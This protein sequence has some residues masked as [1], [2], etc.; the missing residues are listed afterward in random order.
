VVPIRYVLPVAS[1]QVK[2][3]VLLA[4]LDCPGTVT[5]VEAA[6]TRDH[7]ERM[8]RYF[9][10]ELEVRD[11]DEGSEITL[12]GRPHLRGQSVSVPS[13]PS[14]AAFPIVAALLVPGSEVTLPGIIMNPTRSG[15][16]TTLREMGGDI[17]IENMR[18]AGGEP[19]ADLVVKSGVLRGVDV[20]ADR[21]P[22]MIDEYPVLAVAACFADGITRMRGL[23]ELRVKESDR[24]Q[25]VADGLKANGAT[26]RIE[27]DDLV[28]EGT[29]GTGQ[30]RAWWRHGCDPPRSPDRHGVSRHGNGDRAARD[31]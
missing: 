31:D 24:L 23:E 21:A 29:G 25:A 9:G 15:L 4:G 3:A 13:D 27:G 30:D 8:L 18:E 19:V 12:A 16:V 22:S 11:G 5:V 17:A 26:C 14:S 6:P 20:P 2:S 10:A 28:V 7:T 1:A